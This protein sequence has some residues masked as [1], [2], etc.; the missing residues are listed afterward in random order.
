[1]SDDLNKKIKQLADILGQEN[2]P[3]NVKGLL[4]LLGNSNDN[5]DTEPKAS[6]PSSDREDKRF[7]QDRNE[8][9]DLEENLEMVR[10]VKSVM[11]RM[12]SVNDPR[13]NLLSAIRPFLNSNRQK[14]VSSCIKMIQMSSIARFMDEQDKSNY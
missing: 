14:K 1:M 10:K 12:N 3:E 7:K 6:E 4:G 2:I 8:R 5:D 9:S 13:I 11:D